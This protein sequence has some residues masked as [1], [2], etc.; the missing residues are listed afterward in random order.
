MGCRWP[1]GAMALCRDCGFFA[2]NN[3]PRTHLTGCPRETDP[4]EIRRHQLEQLGLGLQHLL[5]RIAG[6]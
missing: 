1:V 3:A 6:I 4:R 5:E 2:Y